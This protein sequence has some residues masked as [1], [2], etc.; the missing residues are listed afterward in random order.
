MWVVPIL[1]LILVAIHQRCRVATIGQTAWKGG[2]FGMFSTIPNTIIAAEAAV[3]TG[4]GGIARFRFDVDT[5]GSKIC[6]MPTEQNLRAWARALYLSE[7]EQCS[8]SI[9]RRSPYSR[10]AP[11]SILG[12]TVSRT[13][14]AFH[15][16]TGAYAATIETTV[17]VLP[18]DQR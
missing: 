13:P 1:L 3:D 10:Q 17:T 14:I 11:I 6:A 12:V 2:G 4:R 7:W 16:Q 18:G 9:H 5:S 15:C 8:Q